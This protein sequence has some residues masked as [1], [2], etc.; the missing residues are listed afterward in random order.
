MRQH[1]A[2]RSDMVMSKRL[3]K[4]VTLIICLSLFVM[5][6]FGQ[7]MHWHVASTMNRFNELRS[8]RS[9]YGTENIALLSAKAKLT[10][11]EYIVEQAGKRYQLFVPQN[12]QI[13]RL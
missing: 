4:L 12:N 7:L 13:H 8:V 5:F 2:M 3:A 9:T 11:K 10:S 1:V 6:V